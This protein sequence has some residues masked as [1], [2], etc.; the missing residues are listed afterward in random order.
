MSQLARFITACQP[1]VTVG[2]RGSQHRRE[3][4]DT[5]RGAQ[6]DTA[7]AVAAKGRAGA[8][9]LITAEDAGDRGQEGRSQLGLGTWSAANRSTALGAQRF[10]HDDC[11]TPS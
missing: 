1:L 8:G 11:S 10:L 4:K 5:S 9:A 2:W 3:P 6:T 7:A